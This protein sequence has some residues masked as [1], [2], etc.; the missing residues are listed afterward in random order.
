MS[1]IMQMPNICSTS[2][3]RSIPYYTFYVMRVPFRHFHCAFVRFHMN[4][5]LF[6]VRDRSWSWTTS[7]NGVVP[8]FNYLMLH[9][10]N[11]A[12]RFNSY[13]YAPEQRV[14]AQ[15]AW[16]PHRPQHI[17]SRVVSHTI[18]LLIELSNTSHRL[19]R[20]NLITYQIRLTIMMEL[21]RMRL[22]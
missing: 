2:C 8:Y 17:T 9:C 13:V 3:F 18:Y 4:P 20:T 7:H 22:P 1:F 6:L 15:F 11:G 21:S 10:Q 12:M 14:S 19:I 16:R 5:T